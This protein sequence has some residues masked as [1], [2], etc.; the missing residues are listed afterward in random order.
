M[1]RIQGLELA[2]GAFTLSIDELMV[3]RGEFLVILG[4]T[5]AG[6][7]VLLET[8]AGLRRPRAGA[9]W[10]GEREVTALPPEDRGVG[11][12]YQDYALFPHLTV[13]QNI[14]FGLRARRRDRDGRDRAW[15]GQ[16]GPGGRRSREPGGAIDERGAGPRA[17]ASRR[18]ETGR[19]R[20]RVD[21][22]AS[23]LGI[24]A[25]LRRYPAG[26]SGGEQQR[27]ALARALAIDPEVLLLDEPLSAL[28]RQTRQELRTEIKRLCNELGATVMHVTH[29]LD[30]GIELG[31]RM[32]VLVDGRLRQTGSPH[33]VTRYPRDTAVAQ[34]L[35]CPNVLPGA[36]LRWAVPAGASGE[37]D[38][39]VVRPDEIDITLRG[40]GAAAPPDGA[41][42]AW[43]ATAALSPATAPL[44]TDAPA[45]APA[46]APNGALTVPGVVRAIRSYSSHAALEVDVNPCGPG[47]EALAGRAPGMGATVAEALRLTVY[48]LNPEVAVR[49]LTPGAEVWLSV[50]VAAMH[51]CRGA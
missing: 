42:T 13:A 4:P 46:R 33:E 7:T 12:V 50:P 17:A 2:A 48:L 47:A 32:A 26:L 41:A 49:G 1:I 45:A 6:K 9:I 10:F 31:D 35:G 38:Y 25:L 40:A 8:V 29:D 39:V 34:L 37:G 15:N 19:S 3:A 21:E 5:G 22:L 14:A 30:E 51:R 11:M 27:V 44:G 43:P 28:D 18:P 24:E 36:A 23:L 16:P 20:E